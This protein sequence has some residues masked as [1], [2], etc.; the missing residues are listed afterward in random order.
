MR[1]GCILLLVALLVGCGASRPLPPRTSLSRG[2][3]PIDDRDIAAAL[4]ARPQ[5][6]GAVRV[7]YFAYDDAIAAMLGASLPQVPQIL[8]AHR[9]PVYLMTG[10][11]RFHDD[12]TPAPLSLRRLRFYA[13]HVGADVVMVFDYGLRIEHEPNALVALGVAVVPLFFL[14]FQ[15]VQADSYLDGYVMDTKTG[16][17]LGQTNIRL[18]DEDHLLTIY[19]KRGRKLSD[20]QRGKLVGQTGLQL[21]QLLVGPTRAP[22]PVPAPLPT[23]T[24]DPWGPQL[25]PSDV[26]LPAPVVQPT[27]PA[28]PVPIPVPIPVPTPFDGD[29]ATPEDPP[30][31]LE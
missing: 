17:M 21:V 10:T 15:D 14:P 13:A 31:Y 16:R 7:A 30:H 8:S 18:R 11:G 25:P 9:I 27:L 2:T 3:E 24:M 26:P 23:D 20:L 6:P 1:R 4:A 29:P 28:A 12:P 19:S 22:V 5:L